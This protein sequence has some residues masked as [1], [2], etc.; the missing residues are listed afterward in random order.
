MWARAI[1]HDDHGV[2][3]HDVTWV[4]G[5]I[6]SPGRPEK[7]ALALPADVRIEDAPEGRTIRSI[8]NPACLR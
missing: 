8:L 1:L 4:R 5:G 6:E 7:I 2:Q 3:P